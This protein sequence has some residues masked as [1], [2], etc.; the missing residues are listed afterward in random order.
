MAGV[1]G[2]DWVKSFFDYLLLDLLPFW[3]LLFDLVASVAYP[4]ALILIASALHPLISHI[5]SDRGISFEGFGAQIRIDERK[6]SQIG[7]ENSLDDSLSEVKLTLPRTLAIVEQEKVLREA[8]EKL[9]QPKVL[10]ITVNALAIEQLEKAF[11]L[12]Y[13]YIF[14]SQIVFLQKINERGGSISKADGEDFFVEVKARVPE[15]SDWDFQEYTKFLVQRN[16][17]RVSST[18]ELTALGKDFIFFVVKYG[19]RTDKPL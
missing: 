11:A 2:G 3:Q 12:S 17:L 9:P 1:Y 7:S 6:A 16:L 10:D 8:I 14:G 15:L 18:V 19:L 4:I 5:F 13:I